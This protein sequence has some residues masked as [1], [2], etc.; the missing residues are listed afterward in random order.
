MTYFGF[1]LS[2]LGLMG[3][4]ASAAPVTTYESCRV[5]AVGLD[6]FEEGLGVYGDESTDSDSMEVTFR[7]RD[8]KV[9]KVSIGQMSWPGDAGDSLVVKPTNEKGVTQ[10]LITSRDPANVSGFVI[11]IKTFAKS[12][13]GVAF[14]L[15]PAETKNN[16]KKLAEF[17][18]RSVTTVQNSMIGNSNVEKMMEQ[19]R[20]ALSKRVRDNLDA[21]DIGYRMGDGYYDVV[22]AEE[23]FVRESTG[24]VAGFLIRATVHYTED[25][26]DIEVLVRL[27]RNGLYL[28][29]L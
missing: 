21:L 22:R 15:S 12:Q 16:F 25:D 4:V 9:D 26:E 5:T 7:R 17:D 2:T 3:P 19:Q 18:C 6:V 14:Y 24:E 29:G 23:F 11:Q 10:Y 27:D 1:F 28:S 20:K 13:R 8:G